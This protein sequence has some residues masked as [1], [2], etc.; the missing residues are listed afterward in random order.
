MAYHFPRCCEAFFAAVLMTALSIEITASEESCSWPRFHGPD[1]TNRSPATGLLKAWPGGGPSLLWRASGIGSG[2]SSVAVADGRIYTTGNI[3]TET[4]ITAVTLKG[5]TAWR[6]SNGPAYKRSHPGTRSTPTLD[7]GNLYHQNADG[8]LVCLKA[9]TGRRIWHVN[10]LEKFD[11]RNIR[12]GLSESV[13]IDGDKVIA[14]PGGKE[15]GLVALNK[16]TGETIWTCRGADAAPGYASPIVVD[17]KGLRQIV[18]FMASSL[19]GV[20]AENGRLLWKVRFPAKFDENI[21]IPLFHDGCIFAT[22][23]TSGSRLYRLKVDGGKCSVEEVWREGSFEIHH[24][25]VLLLDR[26]LY[27]CSMSRRSGAWMCLE[28]ATGKTCWTERGI[29]RASLTW[30]DGRIYGVSHRGTVALVDPS[31]QSLRMVS[32]FDLPKGGRGPVW[33]HPVVCGGRLYLRHDDTLFCYNVSAA[34]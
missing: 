32:S 33:A 11:G 29:G 20:N 7:S 10:I 5:K 13:L 9:E 2:Y 27:G 4:V 28:F 3:E 12:W 34:D 18:T 1:L 17:Y 23:R 21:V 26:H 16:K 15:I 24:E 8:D 14:M 22:S 19:V 25:G 31:P 6:T 30:A